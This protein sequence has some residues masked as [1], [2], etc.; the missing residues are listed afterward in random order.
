MFLCQIGRSL[1]KVRVVDYVN[2]GGLQNLA[3]NDNKDRDSMSRMQS[4]LGKM[5]VNWS[6]L[7]CNLTILLSSFCRERELFC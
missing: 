5:R 6:D 3:M 7:R 4:Q 2:G 1:F